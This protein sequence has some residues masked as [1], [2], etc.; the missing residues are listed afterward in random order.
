MGLSFPNLSTLKYTPIFDSIINKNF[1][2]KNWFSFYLTDVNERAQSQIILGEPNEK[3]YIGDLNWHKVS[4]ESYWQVEMDDIY[5]DSTPLKI[6]PDGP[7]KLVID[8][9]TSIMTGPSSDLDTLLNKLPLSDCNDISNLPELGFKLGD[10]LYTIKPSEYIIFSQRHYSSFLESGSEETKLEK[11]S[12]VN[13]M[14]AQAQAKVQS[15]TKA[16]A[17]NTLN[18]NLNTNMKF[19]IKENLLFNSF[20]REG[21]N[22]G[23]SKQFSCKRAFM[24]LDVQ[25]P[26]GPLWVLGDIFLRKYFTVFDRDSKRIGIAERRKNVSN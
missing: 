1:L 10:L 18:T 11:I 16:S 23:K 24:P 9:G 5:I 26:R 17:S 15:Q 8:T 25:E 12:T 2:R 19:K 22:L 13:K 4:E 20:M 7:C 3:L 6:C 14:A 21:K